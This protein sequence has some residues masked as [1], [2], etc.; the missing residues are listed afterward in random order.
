MHVLRTVPELLRW[1]ERVDPRHLVAFVPTMGFLHEGHLSLL[2]AGRDDAGADGRLVLSVFVNP[3]QFGPNEDLDRYPRDEAGDLAKASGCG[4]DVA[5]C[6]PPGQMFS[7]EHRTWVDVAGL[8][9]LLCGAF[10]PGHF[11]GV[12]T[13]VAKLWGLVRPHRA[14]FG[15]K[16]YQQLTIL[17]HMHR[18]LHL[19][20]TIVGMPIVRE[21]DGLAMSSRNANLEPE[22]R[23]RA[24]RISQALSSV[25]A[26][27]D[28]GERSTAKLLDGAES[29]LSADR[30][31]YLE[32]VDPDA[33]E[34][35]EYARAGA[36]VMVAAHYAGVRLIDNVE[37]SGSS[38]GAFGYA[39]R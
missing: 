17:R 29:A 28:A 13:I 35:I 39:H 4:V 6:P 14:Y 9:R 10:R 2:R 12:C 30:V 3:S 22:A 18:D 23:A 24:T 11:R 27:F 16:D 26:R 7:A 21:P 20:G 15:E 33:L 38:L 32:I 37:L 36:R 25:R 31:D 34:S 19:S 5:F 1:R 8:D